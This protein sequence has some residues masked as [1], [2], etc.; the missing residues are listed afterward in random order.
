MK[1]LSTFKKVHSDLSWKFFSDT[2]LN[3]IEVQRSL[4]RDNSLKA[5][6]KLTPF[7]HNGILRVGGRLKNAPIP[8]ESKHP[9]ILPGD[10][11]VTRLIIRQY[12]NKVGHSGVMHT[13]SAIRERFWITKG[14]GSIRNEL[15]NC[16]VCRKV[17]ARV[18]QQVMADLPKVR[19]DMDQPPFHSCGTDFFGPLLVKHGRSEVKRYRCIFPCLTSRAI[20]IELAEDL[21]TS[22]FI[23]ALRRF[24]SR[25]NSP[26][27]MYSDNGTNFVGANK[28]LRDA[29]RDLNRKSINEFCLT[30]EIDWHFNPPAASNQGGAWEIL[31]CSAKRILTKIF[32]K[33]PIVSED[34]LHTSL[35]EFENII[36]SRP[37]TPVTFDHD[38]LNPLTPN[39]LLK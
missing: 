2:N 4:K 9:I 31:V 35:V 22:A 18:S 17:N 12:H 10:H 15:Q 3:Q 27:I 16:V 39:H 38:D 30:Q 7:L 21:S 11:H 37:L 8:F 32:Y 33:T 25:R 29:I 36:N 1:W 24:I 28:I 13:W 5:L 20:H 26:A 19:L 34:V 14:R 6:S 23:N